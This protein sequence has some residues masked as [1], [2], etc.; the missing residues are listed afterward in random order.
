MFIRNS[1]SAE[2]N[3]REQLFKHEFTD[4]E[5]FS[6]FIDFLHYISNAELVISTLIHAI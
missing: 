5:D 3:C 6:I 2:Y 1:Y 4:R